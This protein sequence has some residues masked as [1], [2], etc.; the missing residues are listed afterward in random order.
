MNYQPI[1][2]RG[3]LAGSAL[4]GGLILTDGTQDLASGFGDKESSESSPTPASSAP[5]TRRL[6]DL[7]PAR[8]IWYPS[9][10]TLQSTF[11]L[12][13]REVDL[14]AKPRSAFGWI[15]ADNRYRLEVNGQ[16]LQFGPAPADPRW[17]EA[18]P[19][20]LTAVLREGRNVRWCDRALTTA[21]AMAPALL[22]KAG[23]LFWLEIEHADGRKAD[24]RLRRKLAGIALPGLAARAITS[25]GTCVRF[26]KSST[27]G[28]TLTAGAR[29]NT[30]SPPTGW[31]RCLCR[32]R[33]TNPPWPRPPMIICSTWAPDRL[34]VNC[35][36]GVFRSCTSCQH[37]FRNFRSRSGSSGCVRP[38]NTS[39]SARPGRSRQSARVL[40]PRWH[41]VS[42]RCHSM[43]SAEPL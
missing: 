37:R 39:S 2:R 19:V 13:R 26:R 29:R 18:D 35:D 6:P 24:H 36:P 25:G 11:I 23:F 14:A 27:R 17:M 1:T 38:R 7:A 43:E 8:W 34:R 22:G 21:R 3:L 15:A 40:P 32:D 33:P 16:R 31:P 5:S 9:G 28:S 20:D 4:Y 30:R 42:G 10:R 41:L 12:F